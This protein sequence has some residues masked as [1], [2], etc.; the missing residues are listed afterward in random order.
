LKLIDNPELDDAKKVEAI[1]PRLPRS[2]LRLMREGAD[3]KFEQKKMLKEMIE[4][5]RK[6]SDLPFD[7]LYH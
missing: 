1:D 6:S 3:F 2:V 5:L 7:E 4:K